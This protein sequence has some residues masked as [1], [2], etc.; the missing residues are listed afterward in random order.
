MALGNRPSSAHLFFTLVPAKLD[1]QCIFKHCVYL[2]I[3]IYTQYIF[4]Q[5]LALP[6]WK[7]NLGDRVILRFNATPHFPSSSDLPFHQRRDREGEMEAELSLAY[8]YKYLF[9]EFSIQTHLSSRKPG[10]A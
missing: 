9:C 8:I 4:T 6:D 3:V 10:Q 5:L 1:I 2:Y 7:R